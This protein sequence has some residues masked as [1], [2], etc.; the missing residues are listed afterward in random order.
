MSSL[1]DIARDLFK[2][3]PDSL[4]PSLRIDK[5]GRLCFVEPGKPDDLGGQLVTNWY[6][7]LPDDI[8]EAVLRDAMTRNI[9]P[10]AVLIRTADAYRLDMIDGK[11]ERWF[12]D[13]D[14]GG[15][16][17]ACYAAWKFAMGIE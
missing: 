3:A 12:H 6:T 16:L 11:R 17:G 9:A 13:S 5:D 8:A 2:H 4:P 14:H 7:P 10:R 1:T 15:T